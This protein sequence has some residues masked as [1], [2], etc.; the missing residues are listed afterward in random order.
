[1]ADKQD[2]EASD[3]TPAHHQGARQKDVYYTSNDETSL[4]LEETEAEYSR[5]KSDWQRI[6][7]DRKQQTEFLKRVC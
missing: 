7:R 2:S 3:L 1:M 4:M 6:S 5:L